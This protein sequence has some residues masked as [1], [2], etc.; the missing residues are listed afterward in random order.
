VLT[1]Q[2]TPLQY[3]YAMLLLT[4]VLKEFLFINVISQQ[5][6]DHFEYQLKCY[7]QT[8]T[9]KKQ[10]YKMYTKRNENNT[11]RLCQATTF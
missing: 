6:S 7:T 3:Y 9:H 11:G 2:A 8:D 5:R 10:K 1:Q 4:E